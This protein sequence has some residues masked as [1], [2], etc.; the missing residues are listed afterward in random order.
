MKYISIVTNKLNAYLS[1]WMN[2]YYLMVTYLNFWFIYLAVDQIIKISNGKAAAVADEESEEESSDD[3]VVAPQPKVNDK[4]GKVV[5]KK[6]ESSEEESSDDDD[7]PPVKKGI[8]N[9]DYLFKVF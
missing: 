2:Y 9:I 3:E 8:Y 1:Q 5:E 4:K 7:E 6:E